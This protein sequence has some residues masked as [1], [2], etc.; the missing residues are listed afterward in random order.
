MCAVE[1]YLDKSL[2]SDM[3]EH[4]VTICAGRREQVRQSSSA[5]STPEWSD[6]S[7]R[8]LGGLSHVSSTAQPLQAASGEQGP[9]MA[10]DTPRGPLA[11]LPF[12]LPLSILSM[13]IAVQQSAV[14]SGAALQVYSGSASLPAQWFLTSFLFFICCCGRRRLQRLC[15]PCRTLSL[16]LVF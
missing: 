7:V 12:L 6:L 2:A 11:L 10:T 4:V 8:Q 9:A 1:Y 5:F 3:P 15:I 16:L 14:P 13:S